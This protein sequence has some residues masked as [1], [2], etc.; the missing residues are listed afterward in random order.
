ME[1]RLG[2]ARFGCAATPAEAFDCCRRPR[3]CRVRAFAIVRQQQR[4][5]E[6]DERPRMLRERFERAVETLDGRE[7]RVAVDR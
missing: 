2:E 5:A 3:E 4:R 6:P 1:E 7:A